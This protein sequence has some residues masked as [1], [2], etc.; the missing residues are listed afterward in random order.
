MLASAVALRQFSLCVLMHIEGYLVFELLKQAV[1][2]GFQ[3]FA[4]VD[5]DLHSVFQVSK[6]ERDEC[7]KPNPYQA[8]SRS[9][10][11][12]KNELSSTDHLKTLS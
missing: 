12:L 9:A 8:L 2:R 10:L 3:Q 6:F 5:P 1:K 4:V 7:F 11:N